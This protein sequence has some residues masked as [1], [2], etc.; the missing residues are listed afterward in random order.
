VT[1]AEKLAHLRQVEGQMRGFG[2]PLSKAEVARA[3]RA[4]LGQ[5]VSHAYLSQ[6]EG[7]R[8]VHLSATTR[9]LLARFYKVHPGY[10]VDDPP[11][12][13]TEIGTH[14]L[15]LEDSLRA[16]LTNR[17]EELLAEPQVNRFL[18]RL[19]EQDEPRRLMALFD[20]LLDWPLESIERLVRGD[21]AQPAAAG[22]QL[23]PSL[24]PA[25]L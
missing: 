8:R 3:M 15:L 2:R 7:G 5:G 14:E 13:Q 1:L 11:G 16:W 19:A 23:R 12:Y 9:D 6:L 10:L 18:H 22:E 17:A 25:S 20:D 24:G 4:E 21:A